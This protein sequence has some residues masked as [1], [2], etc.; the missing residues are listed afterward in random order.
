MFQCYF[1][2]NAFFKDKWL[3]S[4]FLNLKLKLIDN[5]SIHHIQNNKNLQK[6]VLKIFNLIL[7]LT[8]CAPH[9]MTLPWLLF[10]QCGHWMKNEIFG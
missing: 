1:E 9:M 2:M 5:K 8:K 10:C 6:Y 7:P 4:L 3:H